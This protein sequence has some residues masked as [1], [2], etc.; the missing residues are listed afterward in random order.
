MLYPGNDHQ[1]AAS[2]LYM[3]MA[4]LIIHYPS[5][6]IVNIIIP[7]MSWAKI[8]PINTQD[9]QLHC[10]HYNL[11]PT[12]KGEMKLL[13]M[14]SS[15]LCEHTKGLL[16]TLSGVGQPKVEAVL[17][18]SSPLLDHGLRNLYC[19]FWTHYDRKKQQ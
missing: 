19:F 12:V 10:A 7:L 16:D 14:Y 3:V 13:S 1:Q 2:E 17:V 9:V 4:V 6:T 5:I 8:T 11:S 18:G 15:T